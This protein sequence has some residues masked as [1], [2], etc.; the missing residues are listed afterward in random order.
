MFPV[1][2]LETVASIHTAPGPE[3]TIINLNRLLCFIIY[4]VCG[5]V[6]ASREN[7]PGHL[8]KT[9]NSL[10]YSNHSLD[11]PSKNFC[12]K[13]KIVF[14]GIGPD[15]FFLQIVTNS[16]KK[17]LSVRSHLISLFKSSDARASG[18]PHK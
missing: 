4:E 13:A 10:N 12:L 3:T 17:I 9:A 14:I 7:S 8:L 2:C 18:H 1:Y 15:F 5:I 11:W 16:H 6:L